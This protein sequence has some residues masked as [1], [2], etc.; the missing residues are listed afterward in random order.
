MTIFRNY[1]DQSVF[2]HELGHVIGHRDFY[3]DNGLTFPKRQTKP[4]SDWRRNLMSDRA[5]NLDW[6]NAEEILFQHGIDIPNVEEHP[7]PPFNT[8]KPPAG[9]F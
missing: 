9:T 7:K 5:P 4:H 1:S 2:N 3:W 6:K 8:L